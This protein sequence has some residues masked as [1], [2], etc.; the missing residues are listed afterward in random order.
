MSYLGIYFTCV[1]FIS[2]DT[3]ILSKIHIKDRPVDVVVQV[4][5]TEKI[6]EVGQEKKDAAFGGGWGIAGFF[7]FLTEDDK[8]RLIG[9]LKEQEKL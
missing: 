4:V 8:K 1:S 5:R 7:N 2:L 9:F 6:E 3:N